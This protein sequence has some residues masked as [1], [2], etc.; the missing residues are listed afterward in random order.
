MWP[1]RQAEINEEGHDGR[2]V[3]GRAGVGR[4]RAER[5]ERQEGGPCREVPLSLAT[6]GAQALQVRGRERLPV[7]GW[8]DEGGKRRRAGG[9][10]RGER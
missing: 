8:W 1:A 6:G 7:D 3:C 2:L 9:E 4:G 10:R 5:Q